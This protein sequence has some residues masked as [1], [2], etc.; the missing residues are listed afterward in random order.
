VPGFLAPAL[1]LAEESARAN[2]VTIKPVKA[3]VFEEL[4]RLKA[5]GETLRHR[6]GR[7]AALS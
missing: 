1:A 7:P 2:G 3:D 5:A 6:A 4:E